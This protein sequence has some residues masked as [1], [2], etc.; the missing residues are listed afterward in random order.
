MFAR[1]FAAGAGDGC[2]RPIGALIDPSSQQTDLF[3]REGIFLL[4]HPRD[5]IARAGDGL[6]DEAL[7]AFARNEERAGV[8]A[9]ESGVFLIQTKASLLFLGAVTFVARV[10]EDG[11]DV[12]SEGDGTSG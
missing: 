8:A 12:L 9:F 5:V 4:G 10:G 11:V 1:V 3:V 7:G 2:F 6:D